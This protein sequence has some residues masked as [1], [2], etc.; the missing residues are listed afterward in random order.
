MEFFLRRK[1]KGRE[2]RRQGGRELWAGEG[3]MEE[4][5]GGKSHDLSA[6]VIYPLFIHRSSNLIH[7]SQGFSHILSALLLSQPWGNHFLSKEIS[8][9]QLNDLPRLIQQYMSNPSSEQSQEGLFC[10]WSETHAF[11]LEFL[12]PPITA[13]VTIWNDLEKVSLKAG[14]WT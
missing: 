14:A 10:M 12:C 8:T 2:R 1:K 6:F 11:C 3:G 9:Q 4:G 5:K 13:Q 7:Y